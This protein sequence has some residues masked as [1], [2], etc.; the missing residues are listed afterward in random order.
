MNK[1]NIEIIESLLQKCD[2]DITINRLVYHIP[3]KYIDYIQD[4]NYKFSKFV[5]EAI[6]EKIQRLEGTKNGKR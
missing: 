5:T 3:K 2:E 1:K 6:K 4:N